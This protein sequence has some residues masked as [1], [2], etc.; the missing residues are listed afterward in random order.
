MKEA[1]KYSVIIFDLDGTLIDSTPYH[2]KAFEKLYLSRGEKLNISELKSLMGLPAAEIINFLNKKYKIKDNILK[3][4]DERRKYFFE[5][6]KNR[7]IAIK[8]VRKTV[9]M[10]KK[11][12][13]TAIVTGSSR[14]SYLGSTDKEFQKEFNYVVCVD[15]VERAKP[16]P[17][18]LLKVIKKLKVEPSECLMVGDSV[19]DQIAAKRAK[20]D[21][22][23]VLTGY[24]S[25][26]DLR[27]AGAKYVI[28]SVNK[29]NKVI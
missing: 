29:L 8:G 25:S 3:M 4:R 23:G 24:T 13:K 5:L 9:Q 1:R 10:I 27:K 28:E 18:E 26:K 7:D 2:I 20:I 16:A 17:D 15:E 6:I 11:N 22:V 19:F 21:S 14:K 12:Y